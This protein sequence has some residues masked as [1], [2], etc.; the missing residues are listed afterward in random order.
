[1]MPAQNTNKERFSAVNK[2]LIL[3]GLGS[4]GNKVYIAAWNI[5]YFIPSRMGGAIIYMSDKRSFEV[6][7]SPEQILQLF[8]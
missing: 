6:A 8:D 1:M 3:D 4:S 5:L 2:I 7:Q